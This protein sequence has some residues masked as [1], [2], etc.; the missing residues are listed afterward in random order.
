MDKLELKIYRH[1]IYKDIYLIRNWCTCGSPEADW[2]KATKSIK[3]YFNNY[4]TYDGETLEKAYKE[5]INDKSFTFDSNGKCRT[6]AN[7]TLKKDFDFD[8]YKGKL[9]KVL[10]L[11]IDE[12][13]CVVLK[14]E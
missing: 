7:I 13:E 10:Q 8:G 3:E 6:M 9:E 1:K 2:F 11:P 12:F 14:E 5:R 4:E